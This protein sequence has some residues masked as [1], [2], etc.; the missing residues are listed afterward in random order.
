MRDWCPA[1]KGLAGPSCVPSCP[2]PIGIGGG[3]TRPLANV[4]GAAGAGGG[5]GKGGC[6]GCAKGLVAL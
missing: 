5:T 4:G 1:S 6:W 2:V 3:D